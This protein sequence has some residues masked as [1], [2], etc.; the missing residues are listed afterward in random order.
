MTSALDTQEVAASQPA[1]AAQL[2]TVVEKTQYEQPQ[3]E[4]NSSKK[5]KIS[6]PDSTIEL[7]RVRGR[8]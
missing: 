5:L 2:T 6:I 1:E 4:E 7:T 8:G 3:V